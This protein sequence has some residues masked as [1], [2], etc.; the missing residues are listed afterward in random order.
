[1]AYVKTTWVD[2]SAPAINAKNLNKIEDGIATVWDETAY[3][4]K[5]MIAVIESVLT[6]SNPITPFA[7]VNGWAIDKADGTSY[8]YAGA[9]LLKYSLPIGTK[10][11]QLEASAS[12]LSQFQNSN[13]VPENTSN[14]I[15]QTFSGNGAFF[16]VSNCRVFIVSVDINATVTLRTLA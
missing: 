9:K 10:F 2:N 5:A 1:M 11:V 7:T 3:L 14:R 8:A 13:D 16:N 6:P 12:P 4:N 15:G